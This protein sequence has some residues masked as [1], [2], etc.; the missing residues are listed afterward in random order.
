MRWPTKRQALLCVHA[1]VLSL[2]M[3]PGLAS[4][5][6][7]PFIWVTAADKPAILKKIEEQPWARS[8]FAELRARADAA[9]PATMAERREKLM[10]LPLV[11]SGEDD[12]PPTLVIFPR[13]KLAENVRTDRYS[14]T[15]FRTQDG[16]MI[17]H[18]LYDS[19]ND[20]DETVNLVDEPGY[21]ADVS[22]LQ[23]LIAENIA[24]R[25]GW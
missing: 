21:A 24:S 7:R 13:W 10:A 11:W 22:R 25:G 15:E 14:Y 8:L 20:P 4:E 1:A 3:T 12:S 19:V 16:T 17:S 23:Q 18:M 5:T 6:E 2:T 9:A